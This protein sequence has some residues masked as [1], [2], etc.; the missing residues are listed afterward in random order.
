MPSIKEHPISFVRVCCLLHPKRFGLPEDDHPRQEGDIST[1]VSATMVPAANEAALDPTVQPQT[2][3]Q[4]LAP[5]AA[6]DSI[7]QPQTSQ[8]SL[9]PPAATVETSS[10][11]QQVKPVS[12]VATLLMDVRDQSQDTPEGRL[13][14]SH[15][16]L[17]NALAANAEGEHS[18]T[19]INAATDSIPEQAE[20]IEERG[21]QNGK[22]DKGGKGDSKSKSKSKSSSRSHSRSHSSSSGSTKHS[23]R[24]NVGW[25]SHE[26]L[27][28][29]VDLL[30]RLLALDPSRR[31][32]AADA[33]KHPFLAENPT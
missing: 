31:I 23:K 13:S 3:Q 29:A 30:M 19:I 26:D 14:S 11:Q 32:T 1:A 4:S 27:K 7:A 22:E 16:P 20:S 18:I 10:Q 12:A 21:K 25:D 33:L 8:Q 2:S 9:A 6:L 28:S 15:P 5:P 24:N 17:A